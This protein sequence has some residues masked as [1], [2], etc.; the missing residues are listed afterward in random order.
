MC[1]R[2]IFAFATV[3]DKDA[4]LLFLYKLLDHKTANYN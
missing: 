3:N 1:L 2:R 4:P